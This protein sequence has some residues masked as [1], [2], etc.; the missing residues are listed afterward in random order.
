[1]VFVIRR[2]SWITESDCESASSNSF[3]MSGCR[4]ILSPLRSEAMQAGI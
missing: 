1:M 3:A 4:R 2:L